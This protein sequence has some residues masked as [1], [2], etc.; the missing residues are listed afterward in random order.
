M[1]DFSLDGQS[2]DK[3]RL[4]IFEVASNTPESKSRALVKPDHSQGSHSSLGEPADLANTTSQTTILEKTTSNEFD[5]DWE[6]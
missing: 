6:D 4:S 5:S 2:F 3:C 1:Y